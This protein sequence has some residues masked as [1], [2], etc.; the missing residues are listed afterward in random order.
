MRLKLKSRKRKGMTALQAAI[1]TGISIAVALIVGYWIWTV[2]VGSIRTERLALS[3]PSAEQVDDIS[4]YITGAS[5]RGWEIVLK[6]TNNGPSDSTI[7]D[8]RVNGKGIATLD[9][10]TVYAEITIGTNTYTWASGDSNP[11]LG[12]SDVR[13]IPIGAGEEA[14]AHIYLVEDPYKAG[15]T[16]EIAF[17]TAANQVY[18]SSIALP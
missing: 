10:S 5:G 9:A 15:Q 13:G 6:I 16:I 12:G 7:V 1:L 17:V 2:V 3:I 4:T 8:I 11:Q 18:T 14:E